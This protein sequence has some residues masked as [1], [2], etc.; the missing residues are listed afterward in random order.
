MNPQQNSD[1]RTTRFAFFVFSGVTLACIVGVGV[2]K[3]SCPSTQAT[4]EAGAQVTAHASDIRT[5]ASTTNST[6]TRDTSVE[7]TA[8]SRQATIAQDDP[9]LAPN[10]YV[11][12]RQEPKN[13]AKNTASPI[14]TPSIL[15]TPQPSPLASPDRGH[16]TTAQPIRTPHQMTQETDEST[17][18]TT[19]SSQ[20]PSTPSSSSTS[21]EETVPNPTSIMPEPDNPIVDIPKQG[22]PHTEITPTP[23]ASETTHP[24][25]LPETASPTV[26]ANAIN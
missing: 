12:P 2:W 9:Y 16:D 22:A 6:I 3:I 7:N 11:P 5:L 13:T 14:N 1:T 19:E 4:G 10:A 15:P 18:N 21:T 23:Q 17:T 26:S 24:T 20:K 8:L 25:A